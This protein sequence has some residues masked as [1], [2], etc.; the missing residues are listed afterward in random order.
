MKTFEDL[1]RGDVVW[2]VYIGIDKVLDYDG[3]ICIE[4]WFLNSRYYLVKDEN[5]IHLCF[6]NSD[7]TFCSQTRDAYIRNEDDSKNPVMT[8]IL[9]HSY[10]CG[11]M[12]NSLVVL[13]P[14]Y[15]DEDDYFYPRQNSPDY[16][17]SDSEFL[18]E[19]I[20]NFKDDLNVR[21]KTEMQK[22]KKK[23]ATQRKNLRESIKK[24]DNL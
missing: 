19:F 13:Y 5:R 18:R 21:V 17:I 3:H 11:S 2:R 12:K 23:L 6:G 14:E 15:D 8:H 22:L 9:E 10:V 24:L 7:S 1:K 20:N 4:K 16:F